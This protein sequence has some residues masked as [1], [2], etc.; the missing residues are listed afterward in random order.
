MQEFQ[1]E[2]AMSL[3]AIRKEMEFKFERMFNGYGRE[4]LQTSE[5]IDTYCND[6]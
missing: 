4:E 2:W 5:E 1:D 6:Y 3:I